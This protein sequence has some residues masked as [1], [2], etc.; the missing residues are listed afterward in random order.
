M[1]V[2]GSQQLKERPFAIR[3]PKTAEIVAKHV[4]D[5]IVRGELQ[6]GDALPSENVLMTQ[7]GIS[8]PTLREAFRILEAEALITVRRGARGG[9]RVHPPSPEVAARYAAVVL[10]HRGATVDDLQ[11]AR[12]L[13]EAPLAGML[14]NRPDRTAIVDDLTALL[15][16]TE[17]R[18]DDP[19]AMVALHFEF[20]RLVVASTGNPVVMLLA[21]IVE[22]VCEGAGWSYLQRRDRVDA[23]RNRRKALRAA[24]APR[25]P[26]RRG[27]RRGGHGPVAPAHRRGRPV[28][29]RRR[30]R[31]GRRPRRARPR[32]G[33]HPVPP[34]PAGIG[35]DRRRRRGAPSVR[36]R[37]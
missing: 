30:R 24:H 7:F 4:R 14:A 17:A 22:G 37:P 19:E 12:V 28:P 27:R 32:V 18:V 31:P 5:R 25:H 21:E 35:R 13:F 33:R 34:A 15:E 20:H 1:A 23:D 6:D 11:A 2:V 9:A 16:E 36:C 8:R 26:H 10:Q 29:V 3:V